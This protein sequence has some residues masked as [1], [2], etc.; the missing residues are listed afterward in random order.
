[1]AKSYIGHYIRW[2]VVESGFRK[3]YAGTV[4][5]ESLGWQSWI[6]IDCVDGK[7]RKLLLTIY[8]DKCGETTYEPEYIDYT[9]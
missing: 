6:T 9:E 2:W 7:R 3:S 4:V 8:K 1:M 5:S